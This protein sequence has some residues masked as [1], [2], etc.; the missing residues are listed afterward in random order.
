MFPSGFLGNENWA[1]VIKIVKHDILQQAV[2]HLKWSSNHFTLW[3]T[4]PA[5][6]MK[7]LKEHKHILLVIN[8]DD[9]FLNLDFSDST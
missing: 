1:Q 6:K 2:A 4:E 7:A 3:K 5:S 9:L 8:T